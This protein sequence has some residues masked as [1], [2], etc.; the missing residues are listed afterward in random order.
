MAATTRK[1]KKKQKLSKDEIIIRRD[2]RLFENKINALFKRTGFTRIKTKNEHFEFK[3]STSELDTIFIHENILVICE[4]TIQNQQQVKDHFRKK[5]LFYSHLQKNELEL[6]P[7]LESKFPEL[8]AITRDSFAPSEIK[9]IYLYC[10]KSPIDTALLAQHPHVTYM[11]YTSIKYFYALT[12]TIYKS[13]KFELFKFFKLKLTDIGHPNTGQPFGKYPAFVLPETPSG[14]PPDHKIITFYVDPE[15]LIQRSYVLRKDSWCDTEGLYQRMLMRGKIRKMREFLVTADHVY[16][17]NIVVSLPDTVTFSDSKGATVSAVDIKATQHIS[18]SL[19]Q[20]YN[21]IGLIDGQHRVFSYHEGDDKHEKKI[22]LKRRRQQL[23]V[24]GIIFPA[25]VATETRTKQEAKL[26]LEI[27]AE[28]SKARSDLK[29]AIQTIVEPYSPTA[30]AKSII[31]KLA[32]SGPLCGLLEEHYFDDGKIKTTSIVSYGLKHI[33]TFDDGPDS[34]SLYKIWK[35]E[36]KGKAGTNLDARNDY[37]DFCATELNMLIGAFKAEIG[38][39]LWTPDRNISRA[40]STTTING[41]IY[42]L[43][44]LIRNNKTGNFKVY[45]TGF[46]KLT[47]RFKPGPGAY[48]SSHWKSLGEKIYNDCFASKG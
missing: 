28:Q 16:I 11:S 35:S 22:Q 36:D 7:F 33:V 9:V 10:S 38:N 14:F 27:N 2:K 31:S 24:T 40:L 39:E 30:I 26:F 19:P 47:V 5:A 29:Q 4:D 3:G 21:L 32:Q 8:A 43:R 1:K 42:C 46:K 37:V 18:V 34:H 44:L 45:S 48:R 41:L 17:N 13:A 25:T 23:L 12:G 6:I 15:T 20:E